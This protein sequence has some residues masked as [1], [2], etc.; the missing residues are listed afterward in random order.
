MKRFLDYSLFFGAI[1]AFWACSQT[2]SGSSDCGDEDW[3]K[4]IPGYHRTSNDTTSGS[5][6]QANS[7]VTGQ[8]GQSNGGD[9]T[10]SLQNLN[11]DVT[12][13]LPSEK[14][15]CNFTVDDNEWD[16]HYQGVDTTMTAFIEF[17]SDGYMWVDMSITQKT[18]SEDECEQT[19]S[20]LN[21]FGSIPDEE[22]DAPLEVSG[23]CEGAFLT[24]KTKGR[25]GAYSQ[26]DKQMMHDSMCL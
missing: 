6:S 22:P 20:L 10:D 1:L 12:L 14:I 24:S 4:F 21:L 26:G 23:S 2:A 11:V 17:K 3:D 5:G 25:F 7:N 16:Y 18:G 15:D 9:N 8:S 13:K 19:A